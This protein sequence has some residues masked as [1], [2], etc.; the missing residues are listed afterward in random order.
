MYFE[1]FETDP[2][3]SWTVNDPG[4][5]DTAADF[6]FDYSTVGIPLAPGSGP[7]GLHGMKLQANLSG[8]HFSGFSVS[9]TGESFVGDY[10]LTFDWWANFNGPFPADGSGSTNLST[11]GIGTSGTAPQWPGGTQDSLWFAAT[12]DGNSAVDWRVYSSAASTSY[13]DGDPVYAAPHA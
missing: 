11:F 3:A 1:D 7:G 5:S 13:P 6:F 10:S 12:G 9:P 2:T 8:S 4:L